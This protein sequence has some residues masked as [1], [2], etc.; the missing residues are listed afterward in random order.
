MVQ[1]KRF[2]DDGA[3][4]PGTGGSLGL[5][6]NQILVNGTQVRTATTRNDHTN[7]HRHDR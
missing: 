6:G 2:T 4:D 3:F 5:L 1:D 7:G